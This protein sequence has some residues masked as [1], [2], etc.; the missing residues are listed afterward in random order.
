MAGAFDS[1][2]GHRAQVFE[3]IGRASEYGQISQLQ[4]QKGQG[5]LFDDPAG[6]RK[7]SQT[8]QMAVVSAWSEFEKL[9]KEKSVLGF[10]LSGHP[11]RK[12]EQEVN[13]FASVRLG[14]LEGYTD[15]APVR[16][17]GIVTGVRKKVD[18]RNNT[19]AFVT[20]EDFT[21]RA[22]CIVFS[23]PYAKYQQILVPESLVLVTGKGELNGDT[24]RI[25]V[26]D[27]MPLEKAKEKLAKGIILSVDVDDLREETIVRLRGVMERHKG[28][29]PCFFRVRDARSVKVFQSTKF[30]VEPND[31][32]LAGVREVLGPDSVRLTADL[33]FTTS[34]G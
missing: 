1:M 4:E 20:I 27:V 25:L 24:L 19:M 22:E 17:A 7:N 29:C 18:K 9:G 21:G 30:H 28:N 5:S 12:H 16:A 11:L 3:N 33:Q 2:G 23:D 14:E 32:F 8:P 6:A 15:G 34:G 31:L 26:N 13:E 10:Y